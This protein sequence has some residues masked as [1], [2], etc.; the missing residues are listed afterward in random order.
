[1]LSE[2]PGHRG[3]RL[4]PGEVGDESLDDCTGGGR[5]IPPE[6]ELATRPPDREAPEAAAALLGLGE[7]TEVGFHIGTG[8]EV[9]DHTVVRTVEPHVLGAEAL[10][11]L[12]ALLHLTRVDGAD[13]G[14][15]GVVDRQPRPVVGV[16]PAFA[17]FFSTT[18]IVCCSAS[19][20]L[21][22]TTSVP[23]DSTGMWPGP[24]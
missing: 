3:Q 13:D 22:S 2:E 9:Q 18:A 7:P 12:D 8:E 5:C 19:V 11:Q 6:R 1:M 10:E 14:S 24:T 21:N 16:Q 23:A 15:G 17:M 20:G 4:V